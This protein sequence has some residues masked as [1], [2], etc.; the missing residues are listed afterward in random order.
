[1]KCTV[2][3]LSMMFLIVIP[4]V[5][6]AQS[7]LLGKAEL[8]ELTWGGVGQEWGEVSVYGKRID[9]PFMYNVRMVLGP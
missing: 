9:L 2:I 6:C 4:A 5:A 7:E 1:M 8:A 3:L